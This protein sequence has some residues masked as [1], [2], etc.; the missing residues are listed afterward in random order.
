MN[1]KKGPW[2]VTNS[3][4]VYENNWISVIEDKVIRPDGKNGIFG[5][6][7]M[8]E[9]VSV[10]PIDNE[11]YVYLTREYH[12]AIEQKTIEVVS[13]GIED[14]EDPKSAG[15]REL[16]EELGIIA[17]EMVGLGKIYPLTSLVEITNHL[18]LATGLKF[19]EQKLEGTEVIASVKVSLDE[20]VDLVYNGTICDGTTVAL[21][22]KAKNYLS[23]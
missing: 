12:Y 16:E 23:S 8:K 22:L 13:G 18:F 11:G 17:M 21:I 6:V 1:I 20:A 3:K 15:K 9:G 2:V 19:S 4:V 10:L 14:G 5:V 7:K